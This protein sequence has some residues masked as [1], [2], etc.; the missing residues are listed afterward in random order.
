MKDCDFNVIYCEAGCGALIKATTGELDGSPHSCV[1]YLSEKHDQ[2]I[3][4]LNKKINKLLTLEPR[5]LGLERWRQAQNQSGAGQ[6]SGGP[7]ERI[8]TVMVPMVA[9]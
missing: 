1:R 4:E 8:T 3:A 9:G 6:A 5:I 7:L 2:E